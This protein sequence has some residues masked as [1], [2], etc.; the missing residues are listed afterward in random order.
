MTKNHN[1]FRVVLDL[2]CLQDPN[3]ARRGIGRH[4]LALLH[5]APHAARLVG[6]I[7]N[8]LPPLPAEVRELV[9]MV[10]GNAYAARW[11]G[12][13]SCE[14]TCFVMPSPMTHDPIFVARLLS[15]ATLLRAAVV[16]DFIPRRQPDRYLPS[17][18]RQL[19]Y[20]T[21]LRWLARCDLF[22]P[23]SHST[24]D[25]L[26]ALLG[27]PRGAVA[28][29]GCPLDPAFEAVQAAAGGRPAR[30]LLV[31]G[32]GDPRKNPEV[33]VRAH[34]ASPAMQRGVGIPLVV[35]GNYTPA[36][37][38]GFRAIAVAAGGRADLLEIPGELPDAG[39]LDLYARALAIVCP[40]RDEGFSIPVIEGM[41][42][43][44]PCLASDIP[45]HA[46]LVTD[47]DCLFPAADAAA[48][49]PKLERAIADA[50]WR[51]AALARQAEVWPRFRAEAVAGRF[52]A[53]VRQRF[54]AGAP[55]VL[56]GHRPRVALLSP[57]P[58][59]QSGVADYSAATCAELGRL[60]DLH[61]FTGAKRP[62]P[63]RHVASIRPL[64]VLPHVSA[65]FDRVVS[66]VGNSDFHLRI[67]EMLLRHWAACIVHDARLLGFYRALLGQE[68]ALAV[69]GKELGRTVTEAQLTA[70]QADEGKLEALFLGEIAEAASPTIV[71]SL[72][73][74][75]MFRDRYATDAVY[76]PFCIYRPWTAAELTPA[77]R[78]AARARLGIPKGDVAIATFGFVH[79]TKA[80]AECVWALELLRG[81]GIPASLHFVGDLGTHPGAAALRALVAELG[82]TEHVR[83][84]GGYVTEQTYRDYLAA[85]DLGVQLRTYG[86]GSV[87]GALIDCAGAG[88]PTVTNASLGAAI[89][90]PGY[91]RRIPDALSPLLLA[92]ALAD[93]LDAGMAAVRPEA[94]RAAFSEAR[95]FVNYSRGLC[96][97]MGLDLPVAAAQ[98]ALGAA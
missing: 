15:D 82:L 88:L 36:D 72:V 81:W 56:R 78:E 11:G 13:A 68:R 80:P 1:G 84:V 90:V 32:G 63:L 27:V 73:T 9:A 79:C 89:D 37:A 16:H 92:E 98:A 61:V 43:G 75:R 48:L 77:C 65:D 53:A 76:L 21:A 49:R 23:N 47:P 22:L 57:V 31:V 19:G 2:R 38:S 18:A 41:A 39:L 42:A 55:A 3:Y 5:H 34:A 94:E 14:P 96:D 95:S 26:T 29:T 20:T 54:D 6:L 46:E 4:A 7:D 97:A 52:W 51:A 71:H 24:A 44:V 62:A 83:F 30:H 28:V 64:D 87:S 35:A 17:P 60:V 12:G 25:D 85:A 91:V 74:A 8:T 59:D 69:A 86:L 40:S 33:V 58:P 45:A 66:V 93:L 67:F 70:W 10:H 50:G